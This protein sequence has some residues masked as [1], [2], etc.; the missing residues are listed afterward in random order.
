MV[1]GEEAGEGVAV[2][3]GDGLL[4]GAGDGDFFVAAKAASGAHK[5]MAAIQASRVLSLFFMGWDGGEILVLA[6][7]ATRRNADMKR[8]FL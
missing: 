6:S 7:L 2:D 1:G 5:A 8:A 3:E 4:E